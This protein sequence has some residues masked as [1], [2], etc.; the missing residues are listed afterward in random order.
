MDVTKATYAGAAALLVVTTGALAVALTRDDDP[1]PA[2]AARPTSTAPVVQLGAPGQPNRTLSPNEAAPSAI[3]HTAADVAF[4]E[5]MVAHHEQALVMTAL[6][7]TNTS[8]SDLALMAER[9]DV[10]QRDEIVLLQNWLKQH[11][12]GSADASG[13]VGGHAGHGSTGV[14]TRS[15]TP[16]G[17]GGAATHT[18]PGMLSDTELAQ[19]RSARGAEFDR[20]FLQYMIRHHEGAIVMVEELLT[21]GEGGQASDVFLVAQDMSSDQG[22]E[23]A[24]MKAMLAAR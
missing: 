12:S 4:M 1:R 22:I 11:A 8:N 17:S 23:I 19:L 10:S 7:R 21:G 2:Q 6:T 5:G 3:A 16:T 18:M 13:T 9:M 24:K 15:A 20:L 14:G